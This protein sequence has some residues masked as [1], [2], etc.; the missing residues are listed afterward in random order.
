[1]S[2]LALLSGLPR[3]PRPLSL[4][5]LCISDIIAQIDQQL[6]QTSLGGGVIAEDG[7]KGGVAERFGETLAEGFAGAV[8]VAQSFW[9]RD[10]VSIEKRLIY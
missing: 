3:L 9:W 1:M 10:F 4:L 8:V 7:L 6:G 2:E 5:S